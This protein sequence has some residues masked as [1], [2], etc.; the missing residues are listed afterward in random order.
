MPSEVGHGV[1]LGRRH[2]RRC[3]RGLHVSSSSGRLSQNPCSIR[4]PRPECKCSTARRNSHGGRAL[5]YKFGH[6]SS[7]GP[8][9]EPHLAPSQVRPRHLDRPL[10][11]FAPVLRD[12]EQAP[13]GGRLR[14]PWL[15]V[16]LRRQLDQEVPGRRVRE[17][18]RSSSTTPRATRRRPT[19]RSPRPIDGHEGRR[20]RP[21]GPGVRAGRARRHGQAD[22]PDGAQGHRLGRPDGRR[23]GRDPQERR[24]PRG[25]RRGV[26]DPPRRPAGPVGRH[27]G[28]LEGGPR[29]GRGHRLPD[30][31]HRAAA[32]LRLC[33]RGA[34][35][36]QPR[37]HRRGHHR[38]DRLLPRAGDPDVDLRDQHLLDA[39]HRRR[40]RLLVVR[41]G[42]LP[43]GDQGKARPRTRRARSRC[44][45]PASP[46][47]SPASP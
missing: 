27:A 43:G 2:R 15:A 7:Y 8:A 35:A 11:D 17:A 18:R 13:H 40:G 20:G 14:G 21:G 42:A 23:R 26:P 30:R 36:A 37:L 24:H 12:A 29:E 38:R 6:A 33:R 46:W 34:A 4:A 16:D 39:R 41:A 25:R 47:P 5:S 3:G 45:R 19:P 32:D 31:L 1:H 28:P 44:G 22:R 10:G 9:G